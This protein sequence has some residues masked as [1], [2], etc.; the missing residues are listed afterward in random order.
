[1]VRPDRPE[2]VDRAAVCLYVRMRGA[3]PARETRLRLLT[4]AL[5][6]RLDHDA[7]LLDARRRLQRLGVSV[8]VRIELGGHGATPQIALE[9]S[10]SDVP[11]WSAADGEL[12][13]SMGIASEPVAERRIRATKPRRRQPR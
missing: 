2:C 9:R 11:E 1:M 7:A 8:I 4:A 5:R 10:A 6:E 13:R 3:A 12:L